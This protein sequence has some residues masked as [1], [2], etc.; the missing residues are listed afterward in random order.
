MIY[1]N[2]HLTTD[3]PLTTKMEP[4]SL[5]MIVAAVVVATVTAEN[6][7]GGGAAVAVPPAGGG[8]AA[9][10]AA[11][12][13][14]AVAVA[15]AADAAN[16]PSPAPAPT[17]NPIGTKEKLKSLAV[18]V[19]EAL[20][21]A[22]RGN[23]YCTT[24]ERK[25]IR[26]VV[27]RV[28]GLKTWA[29]GKSWRKCT[30]RSFYDRF[31]RKEILKKSRTGAVPVKRE[32][33]KSGRFTIGHLRKIGF[34]LRWCRRMKRTHDVLLTN[35]LKLLGLE[36]WDRKLMPSNL[37]FTQFLR[38]YVFKTIKVNPSCRSSDWWLGV[39]RHR[40]VEGI[41]YERLEYIVL[42]H[43]KGFNDE[44]SICLEKLPEDPNEVF[45]PV[46]GHPICYG[47]SRKGHTHL[48]H[49]GEYHY[50]EYHCP[51][52]RQHSTQDEIVLS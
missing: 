4:N 29:K 21:S 8:A 13:V 17:A 42:T 47:C 1:F 36:K 18:L 50:G 51:E 9:A 52:C 38:V 48:F 2:K 31:V 30:I 40:Y 6:P 49:Y 39:T 11:A 35:A 45:T 22:I 24:S 44:C 12:A 32:T 7:V 34:R 33:S 23:F 28:A 5:F 3:I 16:A 19:C 27:L 41:N 25:I 46:C 15:V 20:P 10:V 43:Q 14:A 37:T 26:Q